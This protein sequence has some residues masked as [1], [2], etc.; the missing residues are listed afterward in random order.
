MTRP[1][2][3][4]GSPL[5]YTPTGSHPLQLP[6]QNVGLSWL[7]TS[8]L[9]HAPI[10]AFIQ[11]LS[12]TLNPK[13]IHAF[14]QHLSLSLTLPVG[15]LS[16]QPPASLSLP[17]SPGPAALFQIRTCSACHELVAEANA[18]DRHILLEGPSKVFNRRFA[19]GRVTRTCPQHA[20]R[21]TQHATCP[22]ARTREI[23]IHTPV[24]THVDR[25]VRRAAGTK[26]K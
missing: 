14:I 22:P 19:H 17:L 18:E 7:R 20:T 5:T 3:W 24:D 11:H 10:H 1:T 16:T 23:H 15:T 12:Q 25:C 26:R 6:H 9:A 2:G 21:N 8:R 4:L 13:P